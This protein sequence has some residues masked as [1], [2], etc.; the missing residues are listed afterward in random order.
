MGYPTSVPSFTT[1]TSL[2]VIEPAHINDLQTEVAAIEGELITSGLTNVLLVNA[3]VRFPA[4]QAA[5]AN[6]NTLDDYEEGSWTPVIGG[7][8]G[9]SGQ[10]YSAQNG[11]Y[12]KVGKLVMAHFAV[13]LTAKGTITGNVEIQGLPFTVDS[14]AGHACALKWESTATNW[15]NIIAEVVA[16]TTTALV[17]G[18]SAAGTTNGTALVTADI[19]NTTTLRGVLSYVASA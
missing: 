2:N 17:T 14:V 10:T 7:A 1:K 13:A 6:A 4:S 5:S 19:G 18:A 16:S 9:T 12:V 8:G 3:G 11:R 15:V